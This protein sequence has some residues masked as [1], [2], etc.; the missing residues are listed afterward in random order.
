[1]GSGSRWQGTPV[2]PHLR[3]WMRVCFCVV[4]MGMA[5]KR[6]RPMG[7]HSVVLNEE[8]GCDHSSGDHDID[9]GPESSEESQVTELQVTCSGLGGLKVELHGIG[10]VV[11]LYILHAILGTF[12]QEIISVGFI[13]VFDNFRQFAKSRRARY[14]SIHSKKSSK[15]GPSIPKDADFVEKK[16]S[17][18]KRQGD[19]AFKKQ[20]YINSSAFYTQAVR[21][22]PY[23]AMLFSNRSVCWHRMGDGKRALQDAL[24]CKL[25]RPVWPKAYYRQ[26]AALMLLK[27]YAK[28]CEILSEG[29]ELD[30]E[31]D[32]ID[33][34]YWEAM[35]LKNASTAA[36]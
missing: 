15:I 13:K 29:L 18:L 35:E 17:E 19:D 28:A 6:A 30:P 21:I 7:D 14:P 22:D 4:G 34:L 32:E 26:G 5:K 20:D 12:L 33:K 27:D 2:L 36:A 3:A 1:M 16:N 23:D 31:S 25:L 24:K 9:G 11:Y 10:Y 8:L